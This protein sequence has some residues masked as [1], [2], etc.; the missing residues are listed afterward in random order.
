MGLAFG[1]VRP[2]AYEIMAFHMILY[3]FKRHM[4]HAWYRFI[5][6]KKPRQLC[7][8]IQVQLLGIMSA[9]FFLVMEY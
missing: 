5:Q 6:Q 3:I 8:D 1:V 7:R 4:I 9:Q 2:H